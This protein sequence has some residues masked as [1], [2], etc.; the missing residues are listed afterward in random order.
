MARAMN[1]VASLPGEGLG[2]RPLGL[3]RRELQRLSSRAGAGAPAQ[4]DREP[5]ADREEGRSI[6]DRWWQIVF[7]PGATDADMAILDAHP[8]I[9]EVCFAKGL[10]SIGTA[11]V[12]AAGL[13]HLERLTNL[14]NLFLG[15]MTLPLTDDALAPFAGLTNLRK[16]TLSSNDRL[17]DRTLA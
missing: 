10:N 11:R 1:Q 4:R 6:Q 17:T 2:S 16:L 3:G 14:E 9:R 5:R 15:S 13:A 8:E 7:Y 12:T